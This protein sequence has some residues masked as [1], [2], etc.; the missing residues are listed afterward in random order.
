MSVP[1]KLVGIAGFVDGEEFELKPGETIVIGRSR[2]C[3]ISLQNCEKYLEVDPTAQNA[4]QHFKTV[5]R[6]HVTLEFNSLENI[7]VTDSS[8]NGTFI[9][10]KRLSKPVVIKDIAERTHELKLGTNE[11]FRLQPA[12]KLVARKKVQIVEVDEDSAPPAG[13]VPVDDEPVEALDIVDDD[14][15]DVSAEEALD[16]GAPLDDDPAEPPAEVELDF[17]EVPEAVDDDLDD[18]PEPEAVDDKPKAKAKKGAVPARRSAT[19]RLAGKG[20][21]GDTGKIDK[22]AAKGGKRKK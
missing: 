19:S 21:K 6:K 20:K 4:E 13:A 8:Q 18:L 11:A 22:G 2:S 10:G 17:E 3:D 7:K 16:V 5:S 9:D 1:L 14:L 15:A 12:K